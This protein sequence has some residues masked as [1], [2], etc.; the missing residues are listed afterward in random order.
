MRTKRGFAWTEEA[1]LAARRR[2]WRAWRV[3]QIIAYAAFGFS[4]FLLLAA[5]L[6]W[7]WGFLRR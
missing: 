4:G 5:A 2:N 6:K 3:L 1:E 7:A